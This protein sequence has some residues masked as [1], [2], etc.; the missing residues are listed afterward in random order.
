[1]GCCSAVSLSLSVVSTAHRLAIL[2][3]KFFKF[4]RNTTIACGVR[5]PTMISHR[6]M[7]ML[8]NRN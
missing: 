8:T 1:M 5:E 4:N 6:F 2:G 7:S 3:S